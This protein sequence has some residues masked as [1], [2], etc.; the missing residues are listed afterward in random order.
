MR[1]TKTMMMLFFIS[2]KV[3]MKHVV[4]DTTKQP[5]IHIDIGSK[6]YYTK[7]TTK[8]TTTDTTTID[9]NFYI[10]SGGYQTTTVRNDIYSYL[11]NTLLEKYK[12]KKE[13]IKSMKN[14]DAFGLM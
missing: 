14:L 5:L 2:S 12:I 3:F 1:T 11:L 8:D 6:D 13:K 10:K 7:E 4:I 9:D